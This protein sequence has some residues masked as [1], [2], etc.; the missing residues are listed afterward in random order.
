[1]AVHRRCGK[2]LTSNINGREIFFFP[3]CQLLLCCCILATHCSNSSGAVSQ[4]CSGKRL[5]ATSEGFLEGEEDS[6]RS[7]PSPGNWTPWLSLWRRSRCE[8]PT[9]RRWQNTALYSARERGRHKMTG[10]GGEGRRE[11]S[12]RTRC[13]R[14][15]GFM[16]YRW[17]MS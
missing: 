15:R 9:P 11:G 6:I 7:I 14:R 12:V 1:M 8:A 4:Q 5:C 13:V 16:K 3:L 17:T 2:I 10:G